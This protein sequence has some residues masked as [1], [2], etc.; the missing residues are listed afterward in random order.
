MKSRG[1]TRSTGLGEG[2]T[3][4]L[5]LSRDRDWDMG[6]DRDWD[7]DW[8]STLT[9]TGAASSVGDPE[10]QEIEKINCLP[11]CQILPI[12]AESAQ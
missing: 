1:R 7:D 2:L 10:V 8:D 12:C 4:R 3:T 9:R 5:Q 11:L 6:W